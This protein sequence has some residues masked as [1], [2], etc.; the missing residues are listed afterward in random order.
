MLV[1]RRFSDRNNCR[2][3]GVEHV[4]FFAMTTQK[5]QDSS[6]SL[7]CPLALHEEKVI[8]QAI[9]ICKNEKFPTQL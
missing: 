6:A 4:I 1:G 7:P 8:F 5:I 3:E 9:V 2:L